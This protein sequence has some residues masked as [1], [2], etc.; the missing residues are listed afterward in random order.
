MSSPADAAIR[1]QVPEDAAALRDVI[2]RAFE[3]EPEVVAL[4]EALAQRL[5]QHRLRRP[6]R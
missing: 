6:R 5:R 4:E 1:R 2:G 3:G